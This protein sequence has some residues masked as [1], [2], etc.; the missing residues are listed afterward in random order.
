MQ[1]FLGWFCYL[2][3]QY[4]FKPWSYSNFENLVGFQ[5]TR[6]SFCSSK[7]SLPSKIEQLRQIVKNTNSAINGLSETKLDKTILDPEI[8][9]PNY[10]LIRKDQN[11]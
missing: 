11:K 1:N 9:I 8:S 2:Y 4:K 10:S 5:K 3:Q 6:A 7:Y